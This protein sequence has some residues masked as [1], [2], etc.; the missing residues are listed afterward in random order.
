[1]TSYGPIKKSD[2]CNPSGYLTAPGACGIIRLWSIADLA[3]GFP[4][5]TH[6]RIP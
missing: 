3:P 5:R 2:G 4:G 6:W 1:M